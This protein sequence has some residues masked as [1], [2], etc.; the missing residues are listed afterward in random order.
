MGSV[1]RI[2]E[3]VV[4][5]LLEFL[6]L[7]EKATLLGG[8]NMWE[9]AAVPR[10]AIGSIKTTDGPAG[11]R[12]AVWFGGS[13]SAFIPCGISLGATFSSTLIRRVGELL[14][15]E[16][17]S[18]NA[19]VL[20]APTMNISRSPFGGRNFENFGE[21]PYLTGVIATSIVAG[22]QSEG[23]GACVKHYVGNEQESR[24]FN[25]DEIIDER[26]LREIYLLPFQMAMEA[27]PWMVM[28]SYNKVNGEHVDMSKK[29]LQDILRDEW[30]FD[31]MTISDWGGTNSVVQ[32]IVAGT[33]L[34]MPGP[35][36]MRGEPL[37]KAIKNGEISEREMDPCVARILH[38]AVKAS[39]VGPLPADVLESI[40]QKLVASSDA[41]ANEQL[42]MSTFQN[43][44]T[45]TKE[46]TSNDLPE[47]RQL[48]REVATE[49]IVLLQN[50]GILPINP[51]K[52]NKLAILGPNA[53]KPTAGG[54]GSA[55]LDPHYITTPYDSLVAGAK[56]ENPSIEI[57]HAKGILTHK[58]LPVLGGQLRTPEG[59][60]VGLRMDFYAGYDLA[61][62]IIGTRFWSSS[63]IFLMTD[64][65]VPDSLKGKP[66]SF[67]LKGV[68][69]VAQS[70]I[71]TFG[72]SS[73]GKAKLYINDKLVI[74][75]S[76]WTQRGDTFM[77]CGSAEERA[78][79]HLDAN[80][81]YQLRIDQAATAPPLKPHDNTLFPV[82]S[83]TR[84]GMLP[85]IDE[86]QLL[87]EA[88]QKAKE[89]DTVVLVIGMNNDW[90][91][92]GVDRST[93]LL[94]C[95]TNELV[96][97]VCAANPNTIVVNQS[98]CAVSMPWKAEPA[99]IL[100]AWYQG[101][102]NGNALADIL[103]GAATPGGKLPITF[104]TRIADHGTATSFPGDVENDRAAYTEGI[105]SG[106]RWFD[107]CAHTPLWPF[108]FGL[109]YTTFTLSNIA[110]HGSISP[111]THATI[112]ATVTNTGA[113]PGAEVVQVY[114]S[115]SPELHALGLDASPKSLEG[116][117]K[118]FL[119]PGASQRVHISL[120]QDAVSWYDVSRAAWRVDP[121]RYTA[122][123]GCSSRD[124][125]GEVEVTVA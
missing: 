69:K 26:A 17:K 27:K 68:L 35:P 48:L 125:R 72:V 83:G 98:A 20:L 122:W 114:L 15:Q 92:E 36:V 5:T 39:V 113:R 38:T 73:I 104:P 80:V 8:Q 99:A 87:R 102:E 70:G 100:Q 52:V 1:E 111:A 91:R 124:I 46:E 121:G 13:T 30:K 34:E 76:A 41:E 110:I 24:R 37:R 9:S 12:G 53:M 29:L 10:L 116:F 25:I 51:Q 115:S 75:N 50:N 56:A 108:G 77:N 106:Y 101:Q 62:D 22:I 47:H 119:Q 120:T 18:K 6:T 59:D 97:A 42:L 31:G 90:E 85:P 95:R 84:I 82:L 94:P 109:S 74:D 58:L 21:D 7:E 14:G 32:S 11:A 45:E 112:S 23:V 88:V 61:G 86:D 19:H 78:T 105:F 49:S 65:D 3:A 54:S 71:H 89:A 55:A 103:L 118:V 67:T 33:D 123:V 2:N 28:T 57:S 117:D 44:K 64:G 96:S 66:Y 79:L 81:E 107:K 63:N 60:K 93:L 43:N 4:A 16:T 40:R